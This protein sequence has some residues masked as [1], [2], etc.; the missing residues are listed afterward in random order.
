[1]ATSRRM[2]KALANAARHALVSYEKMVD[3]VRLEGV[4]QFVLRLHKRYEDWLA[5]HP[6]SRKT[7]FQWLADSRL[8][9]RTF[10]Y[11][12][13]GAGD[14]VRRRWALRDVK[15]LTDTEV[16]HKVTDPTDRWVCELVAEAVNAYAPD[17]RHRIV[18]EFEDVPAI[19]DERGTAGRSLRFLRI[20]S[21]QHDRVAPR[22]GGVA[23]RGT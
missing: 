18:V 16:H 4:S 7:F 17:G 5:R 22:L 21:V 8:L 3:D 6:G 14:V 20:R 1:M 2:H 23:L 12:G 11:F 15:E 9:E 19:A 13:D 10:E